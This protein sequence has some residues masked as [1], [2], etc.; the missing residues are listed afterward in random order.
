MIFVKKIILIAIFYVLL[1]SITFHV[2]PVLP[3]L[4][5]S[6]LKPL[7]FNIYDFIANSGSNI[8]MFNYNPFL[9]FLFKLQYLFA[10]IIGGSN[11][12]N[13]LNQ[14][15]NKLADDY[16]IFRYSFA[17]K[18][19]IIVVV[20]YC[21]WLIYKLVKQQTNNIKRAELAVLLWLINPITIYCTAMM[22]QN[23][24]FSIAF[25]LTGWFLF[26]SRYWLSLLFFGFSISV[27][28]YP[29]FWSIILISATNIKNLIHKIAGYLIPVLV[30]II[31]LLPFIKS[32]VFREQMF[33][34]TL[35]DR[36]LIASV[37]L[38]LG[39]YFLIVPSLLI[40][41]IIRSI[42]LSKFNLSFTKINFLIMSS[43]LI[44]LGLMHFHVQWYLWVIP[45][46]VIWFSDY[47]KKEVLF[48][49]MIISLL[50]FIS[51]MI[52]LLLFPDQALYFG[53]LSPMSSGLRSYPD[54][55]YILTNLK[56]NYLKINNL[57]HSVLGGIGL[58]SLINCF[59]LKHEN[60]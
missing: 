17:T 39:D 56:F 44:M 31:T 22:G 18:F 50:I 23:D 24:I 29:L 43:S 11:Y 40:I 5:V 53:M 38:G 7:Q 2:D 33:V 28:N 6:L 15:F 37:N 8:G 48:E 14:D 47:S 19:L 52:I 35:T 45:F 59:Q 51:W 12:K 26:N 10:F 49:K 4:W 41:L 9:Y 54:F 16:N 55:P 3:M 34:A 1:S 30:F 32:P 27:K 58:W 57:A 46:W 42:T 25:F 36:M 20:F 13:W 60:D 21:A